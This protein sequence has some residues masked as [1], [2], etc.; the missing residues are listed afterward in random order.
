MHATSS[1]RC[2]PGLVTIGVTC[3]TLA[4]IAAPTSAAVSA[5]SAAVRVTWL[6]GFAA[7][8]TPANLDKVGVVEV[9][10]RNAR[11]VLVLEPGTLAGGG[12]FVPLATWVVANARGWQVWS[13]ENRENLL[14]D[15]SVLDLAK[16]GL[17]TSTQLFDYYLGWLDPALGVQSHIQL[18]PSSSVTFAK[19]WGMSVAVAICIT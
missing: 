6:P 19:R 15:Q 7:P 13:V 17:A 8:G 18:I 9:G 11:N 1:R 4:T 14:E 2:R 16:E 5:P 10:P 12:Y 3:V